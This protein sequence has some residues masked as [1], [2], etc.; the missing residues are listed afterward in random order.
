M[1][2]VMTSNTQLLLLKGRLWNT[3]LLNLAKY[4]RHVQR[5]DTPPPP[6]PSVNT[7]RKTG[8]LDH[9]L[10]VFFLLLLI[11]IFHV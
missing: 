9:E 7:I 2:N 3:D 4:S 1:V 8:Y 6:Y 11:K 5:N 10:H